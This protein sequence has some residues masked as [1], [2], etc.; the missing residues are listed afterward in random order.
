V[1]EIEPTNRRA[2]AR[3]AK[4]YESTENDFENAMATYKT[5]LEAQ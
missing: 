4:I 5:A 1:L 2:L 3:L